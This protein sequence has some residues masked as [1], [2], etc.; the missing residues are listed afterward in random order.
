MHSF[1]SDPDAI[2]WRLHLRSAPKEVFAR[3]ATDGGRASFWA[4]RTREHDGAIDFEFPDGTRERSRIL[5]VEEPR[6]FAL[7]YFGARTVFELAADG[8]GGTVLMLAAHGIREDERDEVTAGWV[9]VLLCLKAAVDHGVDLR[10][11][12]PARTWAQGFVDN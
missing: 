5:E 2:R 3:L 11:H 9:S 1:Q 8:L 4:E 10:N 6:R 7:E 12:D